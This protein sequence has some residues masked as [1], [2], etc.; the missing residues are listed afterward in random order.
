M[1]PVNIEYNGYLITTDKSLLQPEVVHEWL[2]KNSYW[3]EHVPYDIVKN[4]F[5]N[6]Y[7]IGILKDHQQIGYGRLITDYATFAYLADVYV[8]E[9]HRGNGLGKKMMSILFE[10]DWLKKL[11]RIMLATKDAQ[12]LYKQYGFVLPQYPERLMEIV[13]PKIYR[14]QQN[15]D[16]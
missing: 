5:D 13:R 4:A 8:E 9:T 3:A 14:N 12:G 6:S 7:C 15:S 2:S 16:K 1:S 10:Q 11:R